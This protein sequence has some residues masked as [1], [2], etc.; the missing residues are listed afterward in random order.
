MLKNMAQLMPSND[1]LLLVGEMRVDGYVPNAV[2]NRGEAAQAISIQRGS[3]PEF[4]IGQ[5]VNQLKRVT[6]TIFVN[7]FLCIIKGLKLC[8]SFTNFLEEVQV[9]LPSL[10][11][12]YFFGVNFSRATFLES[13]K[14][15]CIS[16]AN[17]FWSSSER[18]P[19]AKS[20]RVWLRISLACA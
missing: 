16:M 10:F 14:I 5:S 15:R 17:A 11:F 12:R 3:R 8:H 2:H 13:I 18:G 9:P 20:S 19:P 6:G 7:Q 1:A 4:R